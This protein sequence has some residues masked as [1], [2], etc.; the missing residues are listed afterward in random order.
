VVAM[1][2]SRADENYVYYYVGKNIKKYRKEKGWT[3]AEL[4]EKALYSKQFISNMENDTHQTF[5]LGTVWRLS[6]V[7]EVDIYKFFLENDE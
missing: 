1:K 7:L 5:S 4:A 2:V 6:K 3:Q